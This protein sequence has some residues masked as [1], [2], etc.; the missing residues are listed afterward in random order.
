MLPIDYLGENYTNSEVSS[1]EEFVV[2]ITKNLAN[3]E[4]KD[5]TYQGTSIFWKDHRY[6]HVYLLV[7]ISTSGLPPSFF[8]PY[9]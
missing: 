6:H 9:L 1:L 8:R 2:G 3:D 4:T 7:V 5:D